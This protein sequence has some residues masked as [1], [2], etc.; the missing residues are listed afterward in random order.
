[1]LFFILHASA[2]SFLFFRADE[3]RLA[4]VE[5]PTWQFAHDDPRFAGLR[6]LGRAAQKP[7]RKRRTPGGGNY[8]DEAGW[9]F[10]PLPPL[11]FPSISRQNTSGAASQELLQYLLLFS[12][13]DRF[14]GE[15]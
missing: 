13:L 3:F 9:G 4:E 1:M 15:G 10:N 6:S 7:P 8:D 2:T 14:K 5:M 11:H 12:F